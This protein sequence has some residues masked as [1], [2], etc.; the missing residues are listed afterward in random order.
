MKNGKRFVSAAWP[1]LAKAGGE[2]SNGGMKAVLLSAVIAAGAAGAAN[3]EV[4]GRTA[5]LLAQ[6]IVAA[7][8]RGAPGGVSGPALDLSRPRAASRY[9][10]PLPAGIARTSIDHRFDKDDAVGSVGYLCGL[11]PGQKM[12]GAAGAAGYDPMGKFLGAKL[13]FAFR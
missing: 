13:S 2:W 11:N 1:T 8:P 4:A 5:D 9:A 3:A 12:S 7:P 10:S 6:A